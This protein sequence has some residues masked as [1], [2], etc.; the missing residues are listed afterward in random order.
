MAIKLACF[1][2]S[3]SLAT[4]SHYAVIR[5]NYMVYKHGNNKRMHGNNVK[6]DLA[7]VQTQIISLL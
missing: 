7:T 3:Q 5:N 4:C 2:N 6:L 1:R